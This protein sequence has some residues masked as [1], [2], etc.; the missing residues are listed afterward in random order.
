MKKWLFTIFSIGVIFALLISGCKQGTDTSPSLSMAIPSASAT[1]PGAK[2]PTPVASLNASATSVPQWD[3]TGEWALSF[4]VAN[5]PGQSYDHHY[6]LIQTGSSISGTGFT[7][8]YGGHLHNETVTGNIDMTAAQP[9]TLHISY[10]D[11][12]YTSELSGTIDKFGQMSG[13]W[14]DNTKPINKG[15]FSTKSGAAITKP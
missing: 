5:A 8:L 14:Y 12:S 7:P 6:D 13:T 2:V 1:T 3:I 4:S 15:T 10:D 9:I 11:N